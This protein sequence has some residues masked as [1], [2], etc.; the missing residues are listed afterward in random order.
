MR[1]PTMKITVYI[2]GPALAL[3]YARGTRGFITLCVA[4]ALTR[5]EPSLYEL[6]TLMDPASGSATTGESEG[7][8]ESMESSVSTDTSLSGSEPMSV[9]TSDTDLTEFCFSTTS[10]QSET[11]EPVDERD[12]S[13]LISQDVNMYS[14]AQLTYFESLL[15]LLRFSLLHALTKQAFEDLLRL[16]ALFVPTSAKGIL[17]SLVYRMKR[18]AV[19]ISPH[20]SGRKVPYC[21]DCLS[22]LVDKGAT[23]GKGTC[24]GEGNMFRGSERVCVY[25]SN[26]AIEIEAGG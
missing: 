2:Y 22:L 15:L 17:P 26:S 23:C 8:F 25:I 24:S 6:E 13:T 20:V 19:D 7:S 11:E 4:L 10:T 12:A 16:V 14:G 3:T 9:E 5:V 21:R 1:M 18:I